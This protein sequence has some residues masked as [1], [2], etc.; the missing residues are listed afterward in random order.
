M[1]KREP[2][3]GTRNAGLHFIHH[4]QPAMSIT[5]LTQSF[6][7]SARL[8]RDIDTTLALH[9]LNQNRHDIGMMLSHML[10]RL[11]VIIWHSDKTA[12]QWFKTGLH[13]V[14]TGG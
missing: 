7:V 9:R 5:E 11:D 13:L 3:T 14:I 2:G 12:D 6:K 4:Q 1:L 8:F 10:N